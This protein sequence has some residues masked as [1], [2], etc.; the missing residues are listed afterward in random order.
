MAENRGTIAVLAGIGVAVFFIV[1]KTI[2]D[3]KRGVG[4]CGCEC[5]SCAM[6]SSCAGT[7]K[8]A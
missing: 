1:R 8:K 2:K 5:A 3:R 7:E 4:S 6:R